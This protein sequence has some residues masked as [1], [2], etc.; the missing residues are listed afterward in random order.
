MGVFWPFFILGMISFG[1]PVA[2]I[3]YFQREF[4]EKRK[5]LSEQEF[6][7]AFSLC[8]FLPG[9]ASSQLGMYIGYQRAGLLGAL[10]AFIG[11]TFPS[12][13]ILTFLAIHQAQYG[14]NSLVLLL[15]NSAKLLAVIVVA[16]AIYSMARKFLIDRMTVVIATLTTAWVLLNQGLLAQILPIIISGTVGFLFYRG[17]E[18]KTHETNKRLSKQSLICI[19][20]FLLLLILPVLSSLSVVTLFHYFYQAGSFVFGGGHVVLPLLEPIIGNAIS[21]NVLVE[22][23]AAAQLV[24]GPMFTIA[25]YIGASFTGV[26]PYLGSIVATIAVFLPGALLLFAVLPCWEWVMDHPKF[27]AGLVFI[28]ASV[29]GL[30]IAAFY[31]PIW[32]TGIQYYSDIAVLLIGFILMKKFRLSVFV[33]FAILV[34]Y[35][36]ILM[37]L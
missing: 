14:D 15:I 27:S 4:V 11:F 5:W 25:S 24:P 1:G 30:L 33:L 3:G 17:S 12:F 29:V 20:L 9:P 7:K 36:F 21:S 6:S 18:S 2:H 10:F 19:V 13:V 35:K 37:N 16:D 23:Y 26:N 32:V 22:G 8:Q 34:G 28:N 31:Q